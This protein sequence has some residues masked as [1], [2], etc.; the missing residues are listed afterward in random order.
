MENSSLK[1]LGKKSIENSSLKV[2]EKKLYG[3]K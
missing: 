3:K 1:F 2:F